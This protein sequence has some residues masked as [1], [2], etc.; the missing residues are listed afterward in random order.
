MA[1]LFLDV[2]RFKQINDR[3]GHAAGDAVL[4]AVARRLVAGVR[5]T[6]LVARLAGDEFVL[7]LEGVDSVLDLGRV[8]EKVVA[9]VRAPIEFGDA[10]IE[11]TVSVGVTIYR[12]GTPSAADLLALADAAHYQAKQ[13]GRDRFVLN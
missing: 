7:V 3:H 11:A 1:L 10:T 8:A 12:G 4:C 6:D 13:Q 9:C 5:A 2:D